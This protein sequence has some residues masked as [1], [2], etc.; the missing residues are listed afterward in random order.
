MAADTYA[1]DIPIPVIQYGY[2]L[3]V[4]K[5]TTDDDRVF[6][7]AGRTGDDV[8]TTSNPP[9]VR[10]GQHL[11]RGDGASLLNNLIQKRVTRR[12]LDKLRI[13][14]HGPVFPPPQGD[15][16]VHEVRV[17]AMKAL[18]RALCEA[19]RHNN[20]TV[21]G[22]H[23]RNWNLC[24]R[25]WQGI[26]EAFSEHFTLDAAPPGRDTRPDSPCYRHA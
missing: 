24:R 23:P 16:A 12:D 20:Y 14:I 15:E 9:I 21:L 25:C 11:G 2:F 1:L 22:T 10:I 7:Y 13:I 4:W 18:E 17:T 6:L 8:Y 26:Q 3:Y 5:V 19:L